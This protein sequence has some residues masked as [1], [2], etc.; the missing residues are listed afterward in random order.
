[1]VRPHL[2]YGNT[3]WYPY[4]KRQSKSIERVQHRAT[5]LVFKPNTLNYSER[6]IFLRLPSLKFRRIRGD[7]IQVYKIMNGMDNLD[8]H[9]FFEKAAVNITRRSKNKLFVQFS[10][11]NKRKNA[12]SNRVV[13]TWN[14]L[15]EITKSA[16]T[17]TAL[18]KLLDAD[19]SLNAFKYKYDEWLNVDGTLKGQP[20]PI[21]VPIVYLSIITS[22]KLICNSGAQSSQKSDNEHHRKDNFW[23][24]KSLYNIIN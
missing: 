5:R 7:L 14:A 12:F 23:K 15:A 1:M 8:W 11:T 3:I 16:L 18:K 19:P 2:E 13:P 22:C 10:R 20:R 21:R 24:T 6:M 17:L 9:D 4:L